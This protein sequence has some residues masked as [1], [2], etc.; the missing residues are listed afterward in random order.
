MPGDAEDGAPAEVASTPDTAAPAF[1]K[2][3]SFALNYLRIP[4]E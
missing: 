4:P 1:Q 3:T 2:I